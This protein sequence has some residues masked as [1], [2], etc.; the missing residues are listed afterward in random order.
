MDRWR[1]IKRLNEGDIMSNRRRAVAIRYEQQKEDAPRIVAKGA[2][3][4]ADAIIRTASEN[5]VPVMED[6]SLVNALISLDIDSVIPAE[7]YQATA[8]VLAYVYKF[9]QRNPR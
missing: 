2:G 4:V 8:E 3:D 6:T 7:L 1:A 5:S 9:G